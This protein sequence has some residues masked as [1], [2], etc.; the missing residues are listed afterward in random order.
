[1]TGYSTYTIHLDSTPT[2]GIYSNPVARFGLRGPWGVGKRRYHLL[3]TN[4]YFKYQHN[5]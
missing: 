1:M 5:G 2:S 4:G 3:E